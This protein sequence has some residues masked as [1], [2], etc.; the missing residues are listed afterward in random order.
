MASMKVA[1][2]TVNFDISNGWGRFSLEVCRALANHAELE[3]DVYTSGVTDE[4][5]L[6]PDAVKV[7]R[8]LP[9]W[10]GSLASQGQGIR[11]FFEATKLLRRIP[12]VIHVLVE[13]PYSIAAN[14]IRRSLGTKYVVSVHG[15]YAVVPLQNTVDRIPYKRALQEAGVITSP[16]HYTAKRLTALCPLRKP[17][18]VIPNAVDVSKFSVKRDS[19]II[20][21][22]LG[23]VDGERVVLVVG[24]LKPRKG[25]D[26]VLKAFSIAASV[27]DDLHLVIVGQGHLRDALEGVARELGV[28]GRVHMLGWVDD[29]DLVA[30]YQACAAFAHLPVE[31]DNR[32]EGYGLV[33]LEAG[34]CRKP[35]VASRSGGVSEAV[36]DG[37]TGIVV[38]ERDHV[39]AGAAIIRLLQ[40]R[41]LADRLGR[42]GY[43]LACARTWENYARTLIDLYNSLSG[44]N[45]R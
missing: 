23:L 2:F 33:Y 19:A 27:I 37:E 31:I 36:I 42:G 6:V 29:A 13:F 24:A 34:A 32:F 16:S 43:S 26:V 4:S 5:S 1:L 7:Y 41:E 35:V 18:C 40:D 8:V 14:M 30:L 25:V 39:T 17:V 45:V 15:T 11:S 44:E 20:R 12:D 28:A 10:S 3:I 38:A 22:R 9:P 21:A